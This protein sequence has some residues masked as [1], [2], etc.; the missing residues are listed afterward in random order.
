MF[1]VIAQHAG[2][3]ATFSSITGVSRLYSDMAILNFH[4]PFFFLLSGYM[5]YAHRS[6]EKA[7]L[8]TYLAKRVYRLLV[9][10]FFFEA[11]AIGLALLL[12]PEAAVLPYLKAVFLCRNTPETSYIS[13]RFWFL[14]C[15]FFANIAAVGL[16]RHVRRPY[17]IAALIVGLLL[18]GNFSPQISHVLLG[19]FR[20]PL[21]LDISMVA[22]AFMLTGFLC[23]SAI[24]R[25]HQQQPIRHLCLIGGGAL[26]IYA[27][28]CALNS[29]AVLM[30]MHSYG[31]LAAAYISG[32]SGSLLCLMLVKIYCGI[33]CSLGKRAFIWLGQNSLASF[34]L[35]LIILFLLRKSGVLHAFSVSIST[36]LTPVFALCLTCLILYPCIVL[37]KR[38]LPLATG[39]W[40]PR[41]RTLFKN[42]T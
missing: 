19:Q 39:D 37:L 36:T 33:P 42:S 9:P 22:A 17:T 20:L 4:M 11:V 38:C 41:R 24:S 27:L 18:C 1:L 35:H 13:S 25:L 16:L 14:P 5:M 12:Y 30:F 29:H 2:I 21:T 8:G 6:W 10:Y 15:L 3:C 7:S 23:G 26:I 28:S 34:P 31:N 40:A 32:I